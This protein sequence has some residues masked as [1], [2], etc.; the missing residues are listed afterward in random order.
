MQLRAGQSLGFT[1]PPRGLRLVAERPP[2][3]KVSHPSSE[4]RDLES[5]A[6]CS[7]H[8]VRP[9]LSHISYLI[10][11]LSVKLDDENNVNPARRW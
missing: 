8:Y 4:G 10:A 11:P 3:W 1:P 7:T 2:A 9:S 5:P 6:L